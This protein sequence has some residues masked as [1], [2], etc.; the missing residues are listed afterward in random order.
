MFSMRIFCLVLSVVGTAWTTDTGE[1]EFLAAG[2]G[3][4]GPRV[5]EKQQSVCKDSD[6]EADHEGTHTT[7]RSH[8]K[9]HPTRG[10]HTSP[11][12]K[13]SLSP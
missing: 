13:P 5:V 12:G 8:A 2:G 4:R 10:I 11:L 9:S 7:K 1:G 6:C 3:V